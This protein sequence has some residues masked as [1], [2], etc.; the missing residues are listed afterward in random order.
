M[1]KQANFTLRTGKLSVGERIGYSFGEVGNSIPFNLYYYYFLY[2]LTDIAG[3]PPALAGTISLVAILWDAFTDPIVGN[4]SDNWKS[5]F[6]RRRP[7]MLA[8]AVPLCIL[9]ILMFTK[10]NFGT[11]A[12]F[13]FYLVIAIGL[14]TAYKTFAIPF[15]ALGAE[16]TQDYKERNNLRV[17]AG[18]A[19]YLACWLVTSG[20]MI[21]ID[22]VAA[23]G[24][25][26]ETAWMISGFVF[27]L[28][29]LA[30]CLLCWRFTR[31][32]EI[33]YAQKE[34][35]NV[36]K[37]NILRNV[38]DLIKMKPSRNIALTIFFYCVNF[39]V[40][41]A[42]LVYLMSNYL[43]MS[44]AAQATYWTVNTIIGIALMPVVNIIANKFGKRTALIALSLLTITG[45]L[46]FYVLGIH[47]F[48]QLI[49]FSLAFNFGNVCFWTIGYSLIYDCTEVYEFKSGERREGAV[50]AFASF[51]Q[52]MGSAVGM[53]IS[54]L[55]LQVV[56]Y[57]GDATVQTAESLQGILTLNTLIPGV[58]IAI[59]IFFLWR[60]PIT[61]KRYQA[62]LKALDLR[63]QGK[64][65]STEGFEKLL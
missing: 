34:D 31:G 64:E 50:T 18:V 9:T 54:G 57:D 58:V 5:K 42:A 61:E 4:I 17:Y 2:F 30:G 20:P 40:T 10:V 51:A 52:K 6:G 21:V 12:S 1:E 44:A 29:G 11:Y 28:I 38:M 41:A 24:G 25:E 62:L 47:S 8:A 22:R 23:A 32:K 14:W 26:E 56:G 45:C 36:E 39:S 19:M 48:T 33:I 49:I 46:T 43:N 16:I 13:F 7:F 35:A 59:A 65:Y 15:Y 63:R 60:Y 55:L 53:W 3:V 37:V 27:G